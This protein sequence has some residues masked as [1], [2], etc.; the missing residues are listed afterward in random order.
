MNLKIMYSRTLVKQSLTLR[1]CYQRISFF[2]FVIL[3][4]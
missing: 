3:K 4:Q 2:Q 1:F